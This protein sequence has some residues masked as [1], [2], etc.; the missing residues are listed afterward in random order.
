[1][2]ILLDAPIVKIV[3]LTDLPVKLAQ[4]E[5]AQVDLETGVVPRANTTTLRIETNAE[6]AEKLNKPRDDQSLDR[7]MDTTS[8]L[9]LQLNAKGLETV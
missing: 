9:N 3:V 4:K 5:V 8:S 2:S 6:S 1:M 7:D